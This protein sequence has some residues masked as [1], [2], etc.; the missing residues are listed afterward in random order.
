ME[1]ITAAEEQINT[2]ILT[3][4]DIRLGLKSLEGYKVSLLHYN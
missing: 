1:F 4:D 3:I 2:L